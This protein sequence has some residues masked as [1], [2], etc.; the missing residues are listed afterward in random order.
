[1]ANRTAQEPSIE[2][3][4]AALKGTSTSRALSRKCDL[5]TATPARNMWL[6]ERIIWSA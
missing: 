3:P 6:V 5:I 1:M 4:V 2:M